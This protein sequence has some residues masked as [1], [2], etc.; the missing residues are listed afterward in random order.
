M[1][2]NPDAHYRPAAATTA[3]G[4]V[5]CRFHFSKGMAGAV[6]GR[7]IA[8][9]FPGLVDE[10]GVRTREDI[11][12]EVDRALDPEAAPSNGICCLS[13]HPLRGEVAAP[14]SG[15]IRGVPV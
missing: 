7:P 4:A 12:R 8:I 9:R 2:C 1:H 14:S 13:G 15:A 5:C 6:V 10:R 3:A 11:K